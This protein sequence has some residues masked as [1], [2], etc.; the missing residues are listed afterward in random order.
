[1]LAFFHTGAVHVETFEALVQAAQTEMVSRLAALAS[2][3]H[4]DLEGG[5]RASG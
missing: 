2:G 3:G 1:M 4:H 5:R